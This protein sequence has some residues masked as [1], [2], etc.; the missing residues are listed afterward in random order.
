MSKKT[1]IMSLCIEPEMQDTIKKHAKLK[2]VSF[3]KVVR[4]LVDKYLFV[5]DLLKP[6]VESQIDLDVQDKI[7]KYA[8]LKGITFSKLVRDLVDKYLV[9][10]ES[11]IPVII[12]V[13][14]HL[15]GNQEN[16]QK[17]IDAKSTAIVKALS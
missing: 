11:V 4:D 13:P 10:D 6:Q 16:L 9:V 17:W 3:S 1:N 5:D 12:K 15:R 7:K 8:E 14:V 2:G